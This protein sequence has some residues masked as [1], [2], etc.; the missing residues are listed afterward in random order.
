MDIEI[1][2]FCRIFDKMITKF[3]KLTF[4]NILSFHVIYYVPYYF[5]RKQHTSR[6]KQEHFCPKHLVL[7]K[8]VS[9]W[10]MISDGHQPAIHH[11]RCQWPQ[12][13]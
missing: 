10:L 12:A 3:T 9:D 1:C 8:M 5:T 11:H 7:S 2:L 4:K 6:K 13:S